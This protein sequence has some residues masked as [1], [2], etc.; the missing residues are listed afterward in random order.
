MK[1]MNLLPKDLRPGQSKKGLFGVSGR[2]V[3]AVFKTC[4][5]MVVVGLFFG[6]MLVGQRV[7]IA[8][9]E[10]RKEQVRREL[11]GARI[12]STQL[13]IQLQEMN[14]TRSDLDQQQQIMED[15]A[16]A[17]K[18]VRHVEGSF[19]MLLAELVGII[20]E[21]VWMTKLTYAKE[22]LKIVGTS[23]S[24]QFVTELMGEM[25]NSRW[26]R[27]TTFAYT[28]RDGQEQV[29]GEFRFEISTTPVL[30]KTT[31]SVAAQPEETG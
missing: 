24:T 28:Q 29:E 16:E 5:M 21:Q 11:K 2:Q 30:K 4:W 12:S 6:G 14:I 18:S 1:R 7:A 20:P 22:R 19:A 25:D 3:W 15:R 10:Q 8:D 13:K 23:E 31:G 26:F 17:L 9:Y 27:D